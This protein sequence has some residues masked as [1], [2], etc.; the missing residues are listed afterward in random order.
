DNDSKALIEDYHKSAEAK[1]RPTQFTEKEKNDVK[2]SFDKVIDGMLKHES[3]MHVI[4]EGKM[5][6][7]RELGKLHHALIDGDFAAMQKAF[8]KMS[9][10]FIGYV[11][12]PSLKAAL[13]GIDVTYAVD[14]VSGH[15][16]YLDFRLKGAGRIHL[17]TDS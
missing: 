10:W 17:Q 1:L 2:A 4:D 9:P 11:A 3:M 12:G 13:T 6:Q 5:Q 15:A 8:E 7:I 14:Q 16:A